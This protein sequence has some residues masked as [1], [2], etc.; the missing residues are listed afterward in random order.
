MLIASAGGAAPAARPTRL[1]HVVDRAPPRALEL[2]SVTA[3]APRRPSWA[4][5]LPAIEVKNR[6]TSAKAKIRLYA[7]NGELDPSALRV[8]MGVAASAAGLPDGSSGELAEP[9]D[10]R[11]VQL[12]FR[13]AYHFH[14]APIT[15][16]SATRKG[17][18]GK[19]GTG[20]ALDYQLE[21]VRAATLAAYART[22]PLAG[23]VIYTHPK[24]QYVHVDVRDRSYHWI[25]SSPPRVTW[26]E[27]L[28]RD[29][30]QKKRDASY[31][32]ALDLPEE[33]SR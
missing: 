29:P 15:V 30:T 32:P 27:R 17:D 6:N 28:I 8:F 9:L 24:T 3:A 20:E 4:T 7:D 13:A 14:G 2:A 10:P 21:G 23:V 1:A 16:L 19:H 33:A 31:D 11:L 25:D 22:Y 12:M 18:A 26:R 5:A